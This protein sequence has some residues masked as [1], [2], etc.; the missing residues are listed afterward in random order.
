MT[1]HS[2]FSVGA[3]VIFDPGNAPESRVAGVF[4]ARLRASF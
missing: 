1:P 3:Q 4:Y 2:Q